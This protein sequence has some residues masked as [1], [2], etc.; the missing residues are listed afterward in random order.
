ME[1]WLSESK[2]YNNAVESVDV[3]SLNYSDQ[4]KGY[5]FL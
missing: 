2:I 5:F 3:S 1:I 4:R